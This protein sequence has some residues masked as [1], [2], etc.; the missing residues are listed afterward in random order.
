MGFKAWK[1]D[2]SHICNDFKHYFIKTIG[3]DYLCVCDRACISYNS[4]P[5]YLHLFLFFLFFWYRR[6]LLFSM[7]ISF[8]SLFNSLT[9]S[10][11]DF[12]V[13]HS[14]YTFFSLT[15][16]YKFCQWLTLIKEFEWP[17]LASHYFLTISC[18]WLGSYLVM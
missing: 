11:S 9:H 18:H 8:H 7:L 2:Q 16:S 4:L 14:P 12:I 5:I 13:I 3:F 10:L 15:Y 6:F 1:Q 17:T